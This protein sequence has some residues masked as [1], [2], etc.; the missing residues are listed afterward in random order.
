MTGKQ[1]LKLYLKR[2]GYYIMNEICMARFAE[3]WI[4]GKLEKAQGIMY[5]TEPRMFLFDGKNYGVM[6]IFGNPKRVDITNCQFWFAVNDEQMIQIY[7][8]QVSPI[9]MPPEQRIKL[10]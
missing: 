10:V 7:N 9:V 5:F 3:D 6:N 4:I 1:G 8:K 2:K